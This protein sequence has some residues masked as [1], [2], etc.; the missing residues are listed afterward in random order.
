MSQ[1]KINNIQQNNENINDTNEEEDNDDI[2]SDEAIQ[3]GIRLH[4]K[5][6]NMQESIPKYKLERRKALTEGMKSAI[7]DQIMTILYAL[8]KKK[9]PD[10]AP[11]EKVVNGCLC[12]CF[13][14]LAENAK[15]AHGIIKSKNK[16]DI[17][18][19]PRNS[20]EEE[21]HNKKRSR[22]VGSKK[23]ES[24]SVIKQLSQDNLDA[25]VLENKVDQIINNILEQANILTEEMQN[26]IF[27]TS[28]NVSCGVV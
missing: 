10:G 17:S 1:N 15:Y 13:H 4:E 11:K 7:K 28:D 18:Y 24:I 5:Y 3:K 9:I 14:V 16:S 26:A 27:N 25:G 6:F 23:V 12:Y 8:E 20:Y 22:D 2:L 19:K 21:L